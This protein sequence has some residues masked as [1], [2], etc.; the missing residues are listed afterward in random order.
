MDI[1]AS[2]ELGPEVKTI[3]AMGLEAPRRVLVPAFAPM[4][5]PP[6]AVP[7]PRYLPPPL[8]EGLA[9]VRLGDDY[10]AGAV[11]S[12][13]TGDRSDSPAEVY[14]IPAGQH[15]RW[16]AAIDAYSAMQDEIENLM[17][18]RREA[19]QGVPPGWRPAY[20]VQP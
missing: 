13:W 20:Q 16:Q 10:Y 6:R 8:A 11:W 2:T 7:L 9:R 15:E 19:A 5:N 1:P 3:S 12:D 14:D 18:Q 17:E 4:R